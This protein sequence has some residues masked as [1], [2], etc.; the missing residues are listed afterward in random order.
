MTTSLFHALNILQDVTT[1]EWKRKKSLSAQFTVD[2][3]VFFSFQE[4]LLNTYT[5][6]GKMALILEV[7][8][9]G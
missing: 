7:E 4:D 5:E 9:E 8:G 1:H 3:V 6:Q 2:Y